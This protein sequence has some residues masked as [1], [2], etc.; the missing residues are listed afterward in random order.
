M[1]YIYG[2]HIKHY[3]SS[4]LGVLSS[5]V[6]ALFRYSTVEPT[7]NQLTK[8]VLKTLRRLAKQP[9]GKKPLELAHLKQ[10]AVLVKPSFESIRDYFCL[11]LMTCAMLRDSEAVH[12]T[13]DQVWVEVVDG[14][15]VLFVF[16]E[17][18]K[19]DQ[20]RIGHTIVVGTPSDP[21]LNALFWLDLLLDARSR[22]H[23]R[24]TWLLC[25]SVNGQRLSTKT[26]HHIVRTWLQAINIADPHN[27]GSHSCRKGGATAAASRGVEER[28]I[29][30]H[31]NWRSDCVHI[32]IHESMR[33]RVSVTKKMLSRHKK[34]HSRRP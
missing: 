18:S 3:A 14:E 1:F 23:P 19:T 27:Y 24:S 31:G 8:D 11:L 15:R 30:R 17:K 6:S 32:Y 20:T 7:Q 13:V 4:T 21:R 16:V 22:L 34:G 33:N 10:M 29:K 2:L 28:L 5:A 12:L 9:K 25:N 26:P